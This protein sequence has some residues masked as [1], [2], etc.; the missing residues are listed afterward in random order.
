MC[1]QPR[2]ASC[3]SG[4]AFRTRPVLLIGDRVAAI[5]FDAAAAGLSAVLRRLVAV[6]QQST[7][8][9]EESRRAELET[10]A[11]E[12]EADAAPAKVSVLDAS[13]ADKLRVNFIKIGMAF[14][15]GVIMR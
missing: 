8:D 15:R 5:D 14:V 10:E 4:S 12:V 11:N 9:E 7:R 2:S 6:V 13:T 1:V 3:C